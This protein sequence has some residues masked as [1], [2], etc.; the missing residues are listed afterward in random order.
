MKN[1]I[2]L[3]LFLFVGQQNI[4]AQK[5]IKIWVVRHA[6]KDVSNPK[7]KDPDLS[8]L[9]K[10]RAE[11]LAKYLKGEKIDSIFSTNYKRTRLTGY[12]TA[13]K[14]GLTIQTYDPATHSE[15]AKNLIKN[16]EGKRMLII[17]HSNTVQEI[18][19]AFGAQKP[20]KELT[21]DDYDYIFELT[22]KGDKREVKVDRYGA[23]HHTKE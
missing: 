6:E 8:P 14:T 4:Y 9:G 12:P 7:D 17:G 20:V 21:E 3:L 13:D 10:E 2:I 11:A 5:T 15:L 23:E 19:V 18:L 16:A 22:I 1:L